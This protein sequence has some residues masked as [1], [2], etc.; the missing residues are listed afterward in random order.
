M[1][2]EEWLRDTPEQRAKS[3]KVV[4]RLG[5]IRRERPRDPV[6]AAFLRSIGTAEPLIGPPTDRQT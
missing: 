6:E 2:F 1:T 5:P 3:A 4:A